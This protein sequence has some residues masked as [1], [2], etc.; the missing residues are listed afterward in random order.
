[1]DT[2]QSSR[3]WWLILNLRT[4]PRQLKYLLLPIR[5]AGHHYSLETNATETD[6]IA[7]SWSLYLSSYQTQIL[8]KLP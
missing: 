3:P 6:E 7:A 2:G 4:K 1:M 5:L 8:A